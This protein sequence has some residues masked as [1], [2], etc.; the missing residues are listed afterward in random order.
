MAKIIWAPSALDDI[1]A[2]AEFI[3]RDS[4]DHASLFVDRTGN[5]HVI[6]AKSA[7]SNET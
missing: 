2:I 3:S 5:H 7:P 1:D 6:N 4:A